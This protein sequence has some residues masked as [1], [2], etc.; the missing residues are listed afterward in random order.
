VKTTVEAVFEDGVFKPV[1]RP[2]IPEGQLVQM[3]VQSIERLGV[4][5]TLRLATSVYQNLS[6]ADIEEVEEM[7]RRRVFFTREPA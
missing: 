5:D 3:T 7:T 6:A 4:D 2:A 1:S